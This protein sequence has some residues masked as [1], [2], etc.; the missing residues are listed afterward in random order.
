[1]AT[2]VIKL[3]T[4]DLSGAEGARTYYFSLG[5][6]AYE[7]D[8]VDDGAELKKA[9]EPFIKAGRRSAA[10]AR[11]RRADSAPERT[12]YLAALRQWAAENGIPLRARGRVPQE[13]EDQYEAHLRDA[14][15]KAGKRK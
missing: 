9:L 1:M 12:E 14:T 13:I 11:S 5:G 4:D 7:I 2:K 3:L 8:L 6:T 10:A 15:A